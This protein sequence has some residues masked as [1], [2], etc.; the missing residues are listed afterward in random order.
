M[1]KTVTPIV[2]VREM[3]CI[4]SEILRKIPILKHGFF[5]PGE[6]GGR[7]DN[8]SYK[9]GTPEQVRDARQRACGLVHLQVE[10][11][12]HV[13]QDHGT[14][15][16]SV[17]Q[18]HKGSGAMNGENPV[19]IGD[20]MITGKTGVPLAIQIADCLPVFFSTTNAE[21]IGIAHAGWRGTL[22]N[23]SGAM[24]RRMAQESGVQAR[25]LYIWIGPGISKKHFEV[26]PE[27]LA[28]FVEKWGHVNGIVDAQIR[29]IDLKA[30][31]AHQLMQAGVPADRI[32]VSPHC[33]Y[34]DRRFFSYRR[35][36]AGV[37]HNMA[38]IQRG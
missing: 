16:W 10:D 24:V 26:G 3:E 12:T 9:N 4:Q 13:Y 7:Q 27:V 37:G 34:G 35:D 18:E 30:L 15:I 8:L 36:G 6:T 23:I 32:E 33:T 11:L 21:V 14:V 29:R 2:K 38:V 17:R 25:D 31:N 19:G 28:P 1:T 22:D 5:C 20:A